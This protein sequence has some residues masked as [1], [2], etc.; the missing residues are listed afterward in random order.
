MGACGW[1]A[2]S[3]LQNACHALTVNMHGH[4]HQLHS[5]WPLVQHVLATWHA[6]VQSS[7]VFLS[8]VKQPISGSI[9]GDDGG[10]TCTSTRGCGQAGTRWGA[11]ERGAARSA[12]CQ[13][14]CTCAIIACPWAIAS[15]QARDSEQQQSGSS[16]VEL[17]LPTKTTDTAHTCAL[18]VE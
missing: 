7:Y 4:T 14:G 16:R 5:V 10:A 2:P 9:V 15:E 12:C 3:E 11:A 8:D 17:A 18:S 13:G 1:V 6:W